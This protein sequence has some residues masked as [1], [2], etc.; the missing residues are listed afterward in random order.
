M[1]SVLAL[2]RASFLTATSYRLGMV[3][4]V[5]ALLASVVPLYFITGA[6]QPVAE[7]SIQLE[8]GQYFGFVVVGIAATLLLSSAVASVSTA[9]TG[10]I[11]SGTLEALLVT[12]T[13][14]IQVLIGLTGYSLVWSA[15]RASVLV[16]GA[17]M[18]GARVDATAVPISV[19]ILVL[20]VVAYYAIGLFA[21]A[22]VLVFRTSGPLVG[23]TIG[24]SGLLGGVYYSTTVIPSWLQHLSG[25]VPLRYALR[26]LRM[27]LLGDASYAEALPEILQLALFAVGLLAP[28]IIAFSMALQRARRAGTLAQY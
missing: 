3:M 16:A 23:L 19:L 11:S 1:R 20:M 13:P 18:L 22:L 14:L 26:P 27:L 8:G 7:K 10:T 28:G 12:R 25:V 9:L 4:S 15:L 21:G 6:L 24:V 5:G 17:A 2:M